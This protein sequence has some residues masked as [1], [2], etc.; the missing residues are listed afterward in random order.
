MVTLRG[1]LQ[2]FLRIQRHVCGDHDVRSKA[3]HLFRNFPAIFQVGLAPVE[4]RVFVPGKVAPDMDP[5]DGQAPGIV[6]PQLGLSLR[7][8]GVVSEVDMT[9]LMAHL[10]QLP[11]QF[12]LE[13]VPAK[14]VHEDAHW[15]VSQRTSL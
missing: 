6:R 13:G 7:R 2:N 4:H 14:L 1:F 11:A 5:L 12:H 9:D 3:I 15:V 10:R 8:Q